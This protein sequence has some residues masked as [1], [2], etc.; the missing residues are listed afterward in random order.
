ME[1]SGTPRDKR[2]A[3]YSNTDSVMRPQR[4]FTAQLA[5]TRIKF[6]FQVSLRRPPGKARCGGVPRQREIETHSVNNE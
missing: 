5:R 4:G 1:N 6:F 2:V 3:V